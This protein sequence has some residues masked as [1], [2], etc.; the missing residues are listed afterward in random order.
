MLI[1]HR[2]PLSGLA[3]VGNKLKL[4]FHEICIQAKHILD[5]VSLEFH[6]PFKVATTR[7]TPP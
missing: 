4:F 6:S 5:P 7:R 1:G 2:P 3:T